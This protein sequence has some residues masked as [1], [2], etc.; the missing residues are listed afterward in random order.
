MTLMPDVPDA[1]PEW[2][3]KAIAEMR[4]W[5]AECSW[6]DLEPDDITDLPPR[7]VVSGVRRHYDGGVPQFLRDCWLLL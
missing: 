1:S 5:L 3:D 4:E 7:E 6:A 2:L